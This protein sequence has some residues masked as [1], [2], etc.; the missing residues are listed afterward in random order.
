MI[1][2]R[3]S[4]RFLFV[5]T[6]ARSE[7]ERHAIDRFGAAHYDFDEAL[8]RSQ[9]NTTVLF[10]TPPGIRKTRAR[11]AESI[12]LVPT[13]SS[14]YL[15][16]LF[17]VSLAERVDDAHLGPGSILLR[18]AGD[19][20]AVLEELQRRY[21]GSCGT[22]EETIE[23][24]EA[25]DTIVALSNQP[26]N[27]GLD[28]SRLIA[29]QILIRRPAHELFP[30]LRNEGVR[31]ITESLDRKAWYELRI[32]IYDV[33]GDYDI[34]YRRLVLVLDDLDIGMILGESWTRDHALSLFSVLAYQL[35]LFT[36]SE[37]VEVKR[38]L[39][40]LEADENGRRIAD[41]DLYYR[42]R[43]VSKGDKGVHREKNESRQAMRRELLSRLTPEAVRGL[44][45]IEAGLSAA[46]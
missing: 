35:R 7:L 41:M 45:E 33:S 31:F 17:N 16:S 5:R 40:G 25:E 24:G 10:F 42:N 38:V 26:I 27:R 39:M 11:D 46:T 43:K 1:F 6:N 2:I 30:Q 29:P 22:F 12:M 21:P 19:G 8:A 9:E 14:S 36:L 20:Q 37:P 13:S 44:R 18:V 15:V 32:N 23:A 4:A 34:H 28:T 3:N